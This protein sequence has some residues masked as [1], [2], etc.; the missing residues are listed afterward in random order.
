[1]DCFAALAMTVSNSA[2]SFR[3]DAKHRTRNLEIPGSRCARPGKTQTIDGRIFDPRSAR[4]VGI[5]HDSSQAHRNDAF[6]AVALL[7]RCPATSISALLLECKIS[8]T[9]FGGATWVKWPIPYSGRSLDTPR[10]RPW[11]SGMRACGTAVWAPSQQLSQC[12]ETVSEMGQR[13][14]ASS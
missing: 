6:R 12:V 7:N 8:N 10:N 14:E 11:V 4:V 5:A 3:D 13:L 9:C 1:M 2:P